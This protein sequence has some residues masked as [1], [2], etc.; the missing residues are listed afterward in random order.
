MESRNLNE[1]LHTHAHGTIHNSQKREVSQMSINRY[2]DIQ[3]TVQTYNGVLLH[4]EILTPAAK[5]LN[6]EDI[7]LSEMSQSQKTSTM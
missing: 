1:Y 5:W 3:N 2:T 4:K 6:L 7:T